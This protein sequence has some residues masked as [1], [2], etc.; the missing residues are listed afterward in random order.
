MVTN[1]NID[2][3]KGRKKGIRMSADEQRERIRLRQMYRRKNNLEYRQYQTRLSRIN[4][5]KMTEL[6]KEAVMNVYTNGEQTCR[7]CG[8]GDIDVLCLDHINDDGA[9]HRKENG[10]KLLAGMRMYR[11]ITKND[12]PPIFQVLCANCNLKKEVTRRRNNRLAAITM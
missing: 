3:R 7:R 4:G 12:Y 6:Y 2:L 9:T 11:W 8:Q 1:L 10:G 5:P